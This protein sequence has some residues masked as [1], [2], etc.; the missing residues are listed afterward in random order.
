MT[1]SMLLVE[2]GQFKRPRFGGVASILGAGWRA[3]HRGL[4]AAMRT[5]G[6]SA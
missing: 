5:W 6:G 4:V 3:R 2:P 1:W